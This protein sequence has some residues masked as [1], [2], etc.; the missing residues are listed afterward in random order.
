MKKAKLTFDGKAIE[1]DVIVGSEN[2]VGIDISRL[3]TD[4]GMITLDPGFKNTGSCESKVT[5]LDGE[6]GVLRYRGYSIDD[7]ANNA[8]FLEQTLIDAYR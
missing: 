5:F 1:L 2:E 6:N 4:S 7:L 3:K 8:D